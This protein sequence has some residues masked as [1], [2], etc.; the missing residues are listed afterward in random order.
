MFLLL[1]CTPATPV[2]PGLTDSADPRP[3]SRNDSGPDDSGPDDSRPGDSDSL[4]VIEPG[5]GAVT[6]TPQGGAFIGELEVVLALEGGGEIQWCLSD[7]DRSSCTMMPWTGPVTLTGSGILRAE[8]VLGDQRSEQVAGTFV[9][10]DAGLSGFRSNLPVL[11]LSSPGDAPQDGGDQALSMVV[12]EPPDGGRLSLTDPAANDGRARMNVRGSSSAGLD[13]K[14]WDV[15]L[16]EADSEADRGDAL[17]GMPENG[18]WI[19]YAPYYY[20]E[21][22][23]RNPLA[24]S[25]SEA[26]GRY[27][28]RAR[29]VEVFLATGG[30]SVD[31]SDYQGVYVLMEEVEVDDDRVAITDLAPAD[32]AEPEVTGGY[33]FKIDRTG[34]GE[35]GLTWGTG[36]A[37]QWDFQQGFVA[38]EPSEE[39]LM[40]AQQRYLEGR[41]DALG[42]A[43]AAA[44]GTDPGTGLHFE[45]IM[46]TDSFIDHHITNVIMKNPDSFRLSGYLYQDR[47]GRITAGPVWDFD[48]AADSADDRSWEPTWWDAQNQT[49]DCTDVFDFGWYKPLFDDPEWSARYWSRLRALLDDEL[50]NDAMDA[51]IDALAAGLDEAAARDAEVWGGEDFATTITGLKGW[52]RERHDWMAD[53][54]DA[55]PDPRLCPGQ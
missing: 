29:F 9:A 31:A 1:A 46:D 8:A 49:W 42:A 5:L 6:M 44:D 12:I 33:L 3:D 38:V 55:Y 50:S 37:G 34:D 26:V 23:I 27:A 19:L 53:C 51:R 36:T 16:W 48:R 7:P 28:P 47:G 41:L 54:I 15:E 20:D 52:F 21:G 2:L 35:A 4:T 11:L 45:A 14:S 39:E 30:R 40:P 10:V 17:L 32:V 22:L 13:K 24:F 18:D 43:L 25:V